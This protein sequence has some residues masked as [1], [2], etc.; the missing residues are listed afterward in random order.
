MPETR[1]HGYV[2]VS[3]KEQNEARQIAAIKEFGVSDRDIYID[4]ISGKDFDRPEYN[5]LLNVIRQGDLIVILSLDRLGRNYTEV[6]KQWRYIVNELG[7]DI[8]VLDIPLLDTRTAAGDLDTRFISDLV[9]QILSY[10]SQKERENIRER[11]AQGIARA[12]AQGKNMG[13]PKIEYPSNWD[14]IYTLWDRQEITAKKA[15]EQTGL[16]RNTFYKLA[17]NRREATSGFSIPKK[18]RMDEK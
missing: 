15:M 16:K 3:S 18:K 13:R 14:E 5:R 1:V 10:V 8:K 4:K 7:A 11:Q 12:K 9:L 6:Q 2:R 17:R